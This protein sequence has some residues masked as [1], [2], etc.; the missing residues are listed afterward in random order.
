MPSVTW[1]PEVQK[2]KM[3]IFIYV[4]SMIEDTLILNSTIDVTITWMSTLGMFIW[5]S[6]WRR[7]GCEWRRI[8]WNSD[9][10]IGV[11]LQFR[12]ITDI[13]SIRINEHGW[14]IK[15]VWAVFAVALRDRGR[16]GVRDSLWWK[17]FGQRDLLAQ[18]LSASLT[19]LLK[20]LTSKNQPMS[21]SKSRKMSGPP[22]SA[23]YLT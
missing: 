20:I 8:D 2:I 18:S 6:G 17:Y 19:S 1:P 10:A 23:P 22:W 16:H 5:S 3:Y 13:L 14:C 9:L 4:G 12:L 21:G 7:G 15:Y 11:N